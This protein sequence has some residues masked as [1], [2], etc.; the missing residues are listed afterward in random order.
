ML[1]PFPTAPLRTARDR[2]RVKQLASGQSLDGQLQFGDSHHAY[3]VAVD[4]PTTCRAS[5]CER[6]S[7]SP[8]CDVTR[9]TTITTP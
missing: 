5:P 7:R 4:H 1:S 3:R 2:F 8:W 6:L 9:T